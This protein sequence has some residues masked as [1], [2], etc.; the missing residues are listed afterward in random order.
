MGRPADRCSP[1]QRLCQVRLR[2]NRS[3]VPDGVQRAP[4]STAPRWQRYTG[5]GTLHRVAP[6]PESLRLRMVEDLARRGMI[7]TA[8]IR[9][10]FLRVPRERFVPELAAERGLEAIY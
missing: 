2:E 1:P 6:D 4:R 8:A 5:P 10:A 3:R 7:R 9:D